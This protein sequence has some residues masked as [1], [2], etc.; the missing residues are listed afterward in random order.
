MLDRAAQPA[1]ADLR[2]RVLALALE[3]VR[4]AGSDELSVAEIA[5]ELGTS[6]AAPYRHFA[7]RLALVHAVAAQGMRALG[8]AM[9]AAAQDEEGL[10]R[11]VAVGRAYVGF[12]TGEPH[13]FR[14]MF[15]TP[16]SGSDSADAADLRATGAATF[17]VLCDEVAAVL[18][19]QLS[20]EQVTSTAYALWAL[21]HG[22][23]VLALDGRDA[24]VGTGLDRDHTMRTTTYR[25]LGRVGDAPTGRSRP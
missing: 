14:T 2:S 4:A 17:E 24:V 22:Q 18:D 21:V 7:D 10:E 15:A 12:A 9:S 8:A 13:L 1:G 6:T 11:V 23:A 3:R 19:A 16:A 25:V 20:R 5:R